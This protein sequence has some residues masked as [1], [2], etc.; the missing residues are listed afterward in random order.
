MKTGDKIRKIRNLNN[1]SQYDLAEKISYL[2]QSQISKIEK[3]S[4]KVT[5]VDLKNIAKALN[6]SVEELVN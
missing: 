5:D 2:T 3:G 1:L 6:V 4:R